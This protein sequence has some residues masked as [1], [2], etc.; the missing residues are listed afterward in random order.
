MHNHSKEALFYERL[1]DGKVRCTLCPQ[2]CKI[3]PGKAGFCGARK[4]IDGTLYTL[5]Y[6]KVSSIAMDPIEK[7]PLYHFYPGTQVLSV[8]TYGCNMHCGHCQ[9][10]HISHNAL[11]ETTHKSKH[12]GENSI[13]ELT[14]E[15][16]IKVALQNNAQGLAWTYNEP[17]VWFGY[18][19]DCAKLAKQNHLYT[20]YVTNAYLNLEPLD[21]IGPYLDAYRVDLKGFSNTLYRKLC[22]APDFGPVLAAAERAKKKWDM[23]IEIVTNI[24]PTMNDSEEELTA[25]AKWIKEGLGDETPWHV[26]RFQPYLEYKHLS[27]TPI[28]T[29]ERAREIAIKEGLKFVYIGN[30]YGH[31]A[32]SSYCPSCDKVLI[33]RAGYQVSGININPN[34]TCKFCGYRLKSFRLG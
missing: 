6:N 30:V 22:K 34:S 20:V 9:N 16:L 24:I 8:G 13:G 2:N 17:S 25:I 23:H 18:T 10:W 3:A 15:Q 28:E 1:P 12:I 27:A 19:L 4:N 31:L 32:E 11:E 26:T 7:K 21:M 33:E 29:L 5:I 14:P